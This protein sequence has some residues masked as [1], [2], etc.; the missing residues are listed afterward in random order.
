MEVNCGPLCSKRCWVTGSQ[1]QF[2]QYPVICSNT[3]P[4]FKDLSFGT[5]LIHLILLVFILILV[6]LIGLTLAYSLFKIF[7]KLRHLSP[8]IHYCSQCSPPPQNNRRNFP[9]NPMNPIYS[10]LESAI[11]R[12]RY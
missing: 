5:F 10:T 1:G 3:K 12:P 2:Y 4:E 9:P 8:S 11:S 7:K 6:I